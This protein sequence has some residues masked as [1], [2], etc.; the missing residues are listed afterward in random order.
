MATDNQIAALA[1]VGRNDNGDVVNL[2]SAT[3]D[4]GSYSEGGV[5]EVRDSS[6]RLRLVAIYLGLATCPCVG[7]LAG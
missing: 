3:V 7:W 5:F 6:G 4:M 2:P 1:P